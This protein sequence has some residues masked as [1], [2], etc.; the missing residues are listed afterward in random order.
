[1]FMVRILFYMPNLDSNM[2]NQLNRKKGVLRRTEKKNKKKSSITHILCGE[3]YGMR[4][5]NRE[6]LKLYEM[7]VMFFKINCLG[8]R[9]MHRSAHH[10]QNQSKYRNKSDED[11]ANKTSTFTTYNERERCYCGCY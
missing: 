5:K 4:S 11:I 1:M 8:E 9:C 7:F 2:E 6:I 10:A 3:N